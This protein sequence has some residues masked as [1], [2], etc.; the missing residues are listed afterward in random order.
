MLKTIT[1]LFFLGFFKNSIAQQVLDCNRL[2]GNFV[3]QK[4]AFARPME[5]GDVITWNGTVFSQPSTIGANLATAS[6]IPLHIRQDMPQQHT[7]FNNNN[8]GWGREL[9]GPPLLQLGQP[10]QISVK[11][12]YLAFRI[13]S[14]N[15]EVYQFPIRTANWNA[16]TYWGMLDNYSQTNW[17]EMNCIRSPTTTR[18]PRTRRPGH[19]HGGGHGGGHGNGGGYGGGRFS[20]SE[21]SESLPSE[22][23]RSYAASPQNFYG[24]RF[25][26][27]SLPQNFYKTLSKNLFGNFVGPNISFS[28]PMEIGD[29]LTWNGTVSSQPSSLRVSFISPTQIPIHIRQD[30]P[31]QHTI[32]NNA[33]GAL[34]GIEVFG[35]PLYQLGQPFQISMK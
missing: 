10:F 35:P 34:W 24:F 18:A 16:I 13:F 5:I 6:E 23:L 17:L 26:N 25:F 8:G 19:G 7:I 29:V 12:D 14:N 4:I 22:C 31:N 27:I 15:V 32:F 30:M 33:A 11:L 9:F 20:S 1:C 3:G 21:S 28:R 2:V